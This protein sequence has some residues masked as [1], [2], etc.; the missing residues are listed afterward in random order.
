MTTP[1]G[2]DLERRRARKMTLQETAWV[3]AQGKL[4][5]MK[6]HNG[7]TYPLIPVRDP[8]EAVG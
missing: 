5:P 8:K 7:K 2:W 3:R 6:E 4:G 1:F